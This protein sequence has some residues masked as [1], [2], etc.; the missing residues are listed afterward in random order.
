VTLSSMFLY[1][2]LVCT[3]EFPSGASGRVL[4]VYCLAYSST[5]KA[6]AIA[7]PEGLLT[8]IGPHGIMPQIPGQS[9]A[10]SFLIRSNSLFTDRSV[11][12][13]TVEATDIRFHE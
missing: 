3:E 8:Y 13:D 4:P 1:Q 9:T 7:P 11:S 5:L 12:H 6:E 2:N 10:A